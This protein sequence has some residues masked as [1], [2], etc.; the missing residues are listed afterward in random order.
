MNLNDLLEAFDE[1]KQVTII[2]LLL[3]TRCIFEG[4]SSQFDCR[5]VKYEVI[6]F[7]RNNFD[8]SYS[9]IVIRK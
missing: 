7:E 5:K 2:E 4:I 9:I 1:D 3:T 6:R 8:G